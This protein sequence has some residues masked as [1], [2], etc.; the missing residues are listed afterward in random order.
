MKNL[1]IIFSLVCTLN[2]M[3]QDNHGTMFFNGDGSQNAY[4][5]DTLHIDSLVIVRS[6]KNGHFFAIRNLAKEELKGKIWNSPETFLYDD[7]GHFD[8]WY[9]KDLPEKALP[10]EIYDSAL[11]DVVIKYHPSSNTT[12]YEIVSNSGTPKYYWLVLI[13]GDAFN[14]LTVRCVFDNGRKLI[15]FKNEKAYYK[16]LIPIWERAK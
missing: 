14:Y 11:N 6:K 9:F 15:K 1:I 7:V 13:R 2:C 12:P 16:L 10:N 5:I 8:G 4:F 3:A